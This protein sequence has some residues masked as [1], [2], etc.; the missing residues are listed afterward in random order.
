[1]L[2][3]TSVKKFVLR[4][5]F[6]ETNCLQ[7]CD[8]VN[9]WPINTAQSNNF[10]QV[11]QAT[12]ARGW[13]WNGARRPRCIKVFCIGQ[14]LDSDS[15]SMAFHWGTYQITM[16]KWIS[17]S[18]KHWEDLREFMNLYCAYYLFSSYTVT[19]V[20]KPKTRVV[21]TPGYTT[22]V[23]ELICSYMKTLHN[24]LLPDYRK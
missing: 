18:N 19:N 12:L 11:F 5:R 24:H 13:W 3:F 8:P 17:G 9:C 21:Y 20:G 23:I 22:F 4:L 15:L 6:A 14:Y 2:A 1:M 16:D 7:L 10:L